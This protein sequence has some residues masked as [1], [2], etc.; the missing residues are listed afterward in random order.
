MKKEKIRKTDRRTIYTKN[1][2]KDAVLELM[3]DC[4]F[5]DLSVAAVCRQAEITRSTFYLHYDS[6]SDILDELIHDALNLAENGSESNV[7]DIFEILGVL[8]H[9][10]LPEYLREHTLALPPCQRIADHEKYR[11]LFKDESLS[12]YITK[13]LFFTQREHMVAKLMKDLNL[14]EDKCLLLFLFNLNGAYALNKFMNW[15]K[16]DSWYE[17]QALLLTYI[18]G[19]YDAIRRDK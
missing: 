9:H 3:K 6:L 4:S 16:D 18:A 2:I 12:A 8:E 10:T 17:M 7:T 15:K 5:N 14:P 1:T 11:V 13:T 19:G